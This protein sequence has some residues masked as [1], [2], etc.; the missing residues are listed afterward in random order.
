MVG[1]VVAL[2]LIVAGIATLHTAPA[3]GFLLLVTGIVTGLLRVM[4]EAKGGVR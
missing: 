3:G 2:A 4:D 1:Y